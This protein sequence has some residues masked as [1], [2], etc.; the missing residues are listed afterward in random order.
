M[1]MTPLALS[2]ISEIREQS[3]GQ[4]EVYEES[5]RCHSPHNGKSSADF[6]SHSLSFSPFRS[7][8]LQLPI[9]GNSRGPIK[10]IYV[11]VMSL[12]SF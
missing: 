2:A 11:T 5:F 6:T 7:V 1:P 10:G 3:V 9:R 12:I 8:C 4:F